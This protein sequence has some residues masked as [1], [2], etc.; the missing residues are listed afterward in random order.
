[1]DQLSKKVDLK[2]DEAGTQYKKG[3]YDVAIKL[4]EEAANMIEKEISTYKYHKKELMEKEATIYS[5]IAACY[6]QG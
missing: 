5:N 6:K 2:K 3:M 4:Y 1:M